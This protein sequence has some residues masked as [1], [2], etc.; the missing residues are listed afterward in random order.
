MYSFNCQICGVD[1]ATARIR[2]ADEPPTAAWNFEGADFVGFSV[3]PYQDEF[4]DKDCRECTTVDR[5]SARPPEV[6]AWPDEDDE[7]DPD[8]TP[9][10]Q[11]LSDE[12]PLEYD[13]GWETDSA[14][15]GLEALAISG[16]EICSDEEN[17]HSKNTP[18]QYPFSDLYAPPLPERLPHGTWHNGFSYYAGDRKHPQKWP[19][20]CRGSDPDRPLGAVEHIASPSCQSLQGIN[21]QILSV[22]QMKNC[23]NVRYLVP[24]SPGWKADGSDQLLE[25][26]SSNLFYVSGESSGSNMVE[27]DSMAKTCRALFKLTQSAFREVVMSDIPWLWEVF[28]GGDYPASRDSRPTWDPLC[29]LGIPPPT[30]PVGLESE[31]EEDFLW[32]T[33][34]FENPEMEQVRNTAR[35]LNRQRREEIIAPYHKKLK[36]LLED[37]HS[38]RGKVEAWIQGTGQQGDMNWRRLWFMF[39]PAT[40]PLPGICNRAR[41]WEDCESILDN[42]ALAHEV[43]DIDDR[44][45]ELKAKIS[46]FI[47]ENSYKMDDPD[48]DVPGWLYPQ[49]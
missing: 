35:A 2:T 9:D 25:G 38:F 4:R 13:S 27:I 41:I 28:E 37:W 40:S 16:D 34:I 32:E 20:F 33:I 11:S 23:R 5:G 18:D 7:D 42:I 45:G 19:L 22:A 12:E 44:H 8:W 14:E 1:M 26:S 48:P 46:E 24:K 15:S 43:G 47:D 36:V 31:E 3:W 10:K 49:Q 29:P 39:N 30:L 17:S 6:G 21:G